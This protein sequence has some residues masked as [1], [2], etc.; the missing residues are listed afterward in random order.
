MRIHFAL[1]AALCMVLSLAK[2]GSAVAQAQTGTAQA[3]ASDGVVYKPPMRG[4]P[5]RR[6][7]GATRGGG[8]PDLVLQVLAPDQTGLTTQSQPVLYW[9]ASKPINTLIELTLISDAAESPV[10]SKNFTVTP[11]GVQAI[12]LGSHGVTLAP[13]TEYEWFVSVVT[14]VNQRS[15]DMAS[16][17]TIRRVAPDPAVAARVAA[18]TERMVPR[19]YAEAGLWYDAIASLSKLIERNPSDT[20]LRNLRA[21]LLEQIGLPAAA[22]FDRAGR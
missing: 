4:A 20:E 16:G 10:L 1:M 18:A 5:A 14:N 7:G 9:Y 8:D 6:V 22:A 12:D 3:Q 2:P 17:G 19:I 15:K 13:D 11:G 21:S